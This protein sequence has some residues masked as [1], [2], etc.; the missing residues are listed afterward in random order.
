[1]ASRSSETR[2]RI[3]RAA[4]EHFL[5]KGYQR[6]SL[7]AIATSAGVT[8]ATVL[9]HFASKDQL[10]A[11][12]LEPLVAELERAVAEA[13]AQP[14]H[15]RPWVLIE[16]WLDVLLRHRGS[17]SVFLQYARVGSG[18]EVDRLAAVYA[19][20]VE[21]YFRACELMSGPGA[22][23]RESVRASQALSLVSDPVWHNQHVDADVLR[24]LIL[25]GVQQFLGSRPADA[26]SI[27]S[28]RSAQ[29]ATLG[30]PVPARRRGRPVTL[31]P[32]QVRAAA[33]LH[34][35]GSLTVDEIAARFGVSRTTLYRHLR[36]ASA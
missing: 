1:M 24:E 35:A 15:R 25:E 23:L 20:V 31:S 13:A 2:A 30:A 17:L 3:L 33:E 6:T 7:E 32:E 28:S 10:V 34:R 4:T 21:V 14:P 29:V 16:G 18:S 9:Y 27:R 5:S 19:R 12:M 36:Q 22:G 8:K 11:E 26:R